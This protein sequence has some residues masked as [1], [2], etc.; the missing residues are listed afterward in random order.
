MGAILGILA[1][2]PYL[3]VFRLSNV[4]FALYPE[5]DPI[6]APISLDHLTQVTLMDITQA[7]EDPFS[8]SNVVIGYILQRIRFRT[9]TAFTV[10]TK[11][12]TNASLTPEEFINVV[13]SPV[14]ALAYLSLA[15]GPQRADVDVKFG[16][17]GFLFRIQDGLQSP[18]IVFSADV[19]GLPEQVAKEWVVESLRQASTTP[20]DLRLYFTS[21]ECGSEPSSISLEEIFHFQLWESVVDLTL[22]GNP[23][24]PPDV[25]RDLLRLLSTPC[26]SE[27]GIMVMPFPKLQ[28]LGIS[29]VPG[30]KGKYMLAMVQARFAP[31][32]PTEAASHSVVPV[33]LMLH[34]GNGV[35]AWGRSYQD[36]ILAVPGVKGIKTGVSHPALRL[37]RSSSPTVSEPD[38][39]PPYDFGRY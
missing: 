11:L 35:G 6:P 27:D 37:A 18:S 33:P 2:N 21:N 34:C 32:G 24:T 20:M 8:G 15:D 17:N 22:T 3:E 9:G 16:G 4:R 10:R 23:Q 36:K 19:D 1:T 39:P 5:H 12:K 25:G 30:I 28:H 38:W 29:V 31:P 26:M 14:E 7:T 13:P